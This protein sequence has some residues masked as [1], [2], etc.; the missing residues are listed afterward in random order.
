MSIIQAFLLGLLQGLTEFL[1]ISSSGHLAIGKRLLG[2]DAAIA[3]SP[4]F[5][6]V[7]HIATALSILVVFRRDIWQLLAGSVE[8]SH[9]P[10]L[11][12]VWLLKPRFIRAAGAV[13]FR[14]N[15]HS[16]YLLKIALATLPIAVVG[17]FFKDKVEALF[18]AGLLLVGCMLLLTA[19]LLL[20]THIYKP[21]KPHAITFVDAAIIG[22]AQCAAIMPGLSRS[23][24]TIA[25]SLL[26]GNRRSDA[27]RFSFLIVLVPILGEAALGILKGEMAAA[28]AAIGM[29]PLLTGFLTAFVAGAAT[30][31]FMV[32]FVKRS[33]LLG[34]AIYCMIAGIFAILI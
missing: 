20:L 28:S 32:E 9:S 25:A 18:A 8:Y 33:S 26:L 6:I 30:C 29:L 17:V 14:W 2:L 11:L 10:K 7:V 27:A 15:E 12:R 23:G 34:F 19:L 4:T 21:R 22:A 5:E 16:Q 13:S 24:A 31:K 1:P 3:D